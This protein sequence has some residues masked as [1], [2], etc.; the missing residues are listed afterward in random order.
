M[1][2]GGIVWCWGGHG[3]RGRE[4]DRCG[5]GMDRV[6]GAGRVGVSGLSYRIYG[7][8]NQLVLDCGQATAE[9]LDFCGG[10]FFLSRSMRI[11]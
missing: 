9:R 3:K 7:D 2:S 5:P 10:L 6:S 11:G 1:G 4:G 8:F